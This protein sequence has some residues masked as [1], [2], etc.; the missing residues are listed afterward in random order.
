MAAPK[1]SL[2]LPA[3]LEEENLRLLLPRIR[4]VT[5]K[6]EA[7]GEGPWEVLIVDTVEPLDATEQACRE[8]GARYVRRG[9][10]NF[11]GDAV[12]TA[13]RQA[14]G[15]WI[16]FM[17][18]DGSHQPEFIPKLV[19]ETKHAQLVIASRYVEGG[20]TEN[21]KALI[22]M[23]WILNRTYSFVL[24][25]KVKDV[26]NSFKLY[27]ADLLKEL[28]L[29]CNNFDIIEEILF[30]ICRKHRDLSIREVP[31]S[32]KKRMFG[33]TKRNLVAFI[34]TYLVTMFRLRFM[35]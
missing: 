8:L 1:Y 16:L 30:K 18:A 26:S 27:R 28:T 2:C 4:E 31:F 33:E 32:F 20:Y 10:S 21:D 12:R 3:Y 14:Q 22:W 13:I 23:S 25:L 5:A 17:D 6:L 7:A 9:P 34:F 29:K 35:T 11:F 15:Q 24:G 19:E